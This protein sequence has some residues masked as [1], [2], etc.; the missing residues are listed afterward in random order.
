MTWLQQNLKIALAAIAL[1]AVALVFIISGESGPEAEVY[2]V[3]DEICD[4]IS[5][6]SPK[7][8]LS[9]LTSAKELSGHFVESPYLVAWP[10]QA[11]VTNRDAVTGLF[12]YLFSYATEAKI[13]MS[14]RQATID[15]D[16][17]I[18]TATITG[19]A[20]VGGSSERHSGRYRIALEKVDGDWLITTSEPSN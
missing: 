9:Q 8:K 14:S 2:A 13:S 1:A 7:P 20:T 11:A 10:G 16:R 15:G 4:G 5:Y 3:L 17:A 12:V 18:V 6:D 19:K